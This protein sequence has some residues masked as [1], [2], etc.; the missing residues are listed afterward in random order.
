V[1]RYTY[2]SKGG[3]YMKNQKKNTILSEDGLYREC[4]PDEIINRPT[5]VEGFPVE[6]MYIG[7][8]L[9]IYEE[10]RDLELWTYNP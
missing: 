10:S 8:Y 2:L 7:L 6:R 9:E 5:G 1:L 4:R 3:R